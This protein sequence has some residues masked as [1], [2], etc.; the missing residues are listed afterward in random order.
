MVVVLV[1]CTVGVVVVGGGGAELQVSITWV[2][3]LNSCNNRS[4]VILYDG[5]DEVNDEVNDK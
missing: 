4:H 5:D 3:V 1:V 2:H